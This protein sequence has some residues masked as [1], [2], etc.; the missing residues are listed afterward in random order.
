MRSE[1]LTK[2]TTVGSLSS[3]DQELMDTTNGT[4][5]VDSDIINSESPAQ[6]VCTVCG[7]D[8]D[9]LHFGQYTCRVGTY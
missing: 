2:L 4:S 8:S 5:T 6:H 3:P 7:D 9:G 1:F